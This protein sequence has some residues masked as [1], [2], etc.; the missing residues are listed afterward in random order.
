MDGGQEKKSGMVPDFVS[1]LGSGTRNRNGFFPLSAPSALL[2]LGQTIFGVRCMYQTSSRYAIMHV[3]VL[4]LVA[5]VGEYS[6]HT[7]E[8]SMP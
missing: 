1:F 2:S 6:M 7:G 3:C 4:C 5:L 8:Y